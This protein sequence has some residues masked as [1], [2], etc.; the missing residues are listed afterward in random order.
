MLF[1]LSNRSL[2]PLRKSSTIRVFHS[3]YLPFHFHLFM[4][5]RRRGCSASRFNFYFI[6][7]FFFKRNFSFYNSFFYSFSYVETLF[8]PLFVVVVVVCSHRR[9]FILIRTCK[10][11]MRLCFLYVQSALMLFSALLLFSIFLYSES[12]RKS[13]DKKIPLNITLQTFY[14]GGTVGDVEVKLY[15][16]RRI[17]FT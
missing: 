12:V 8:Q 15:G 1:F 3:I 4:C 7:P 16:T 5:G 11:A 10:C 2:I 6:F 13:K 14:V 17:E 9:I